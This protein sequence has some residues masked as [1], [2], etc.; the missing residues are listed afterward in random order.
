M[1]LSFIFQSTI[2][3]EQETISKTE[4]F[5]SK[6]EKLKAKKS[7]DLKTSSIEDLFPL[8]R[9]ECSRS[10]KDRVCLTIIC[11]LRKKLS[12]EQI[13]AFF[14][15]LKKMLESL[16]REIF[17]NARPRKLILAK[18]LMM[19][20]Q[21]FKK[22]STKIRFLLSLALAI[23]S[24]NITKMLFDRGKHLYFLSSVVLDSLS[25]VADD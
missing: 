22:A 8:V 21:I 19:W 25:K 13:F 18:F 11:S 4:M 14:S 7:G 2:A 20:N 5:E 10:S 3:D 16:F 1:D 15:L 17:S 12:R 6:R 23:M 9:I 24:S